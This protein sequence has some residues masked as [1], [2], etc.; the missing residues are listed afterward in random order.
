MIVFWIWVLSQVTLYSREQQ[1][2][3]KRFHVP[4]RTIGI[5]SNQ[6]FRGGG[7]RFCGFWMEDQVWWEDDV[8]S[9]EAAECTGRSSDSSSTLENVLGEV[10]VQC[11]AVPEIEASKVHHD[12]ALM[13]RQENEGRS[14]NGERCAR[15]Y[16][17]WEKLLG[18]ARVRLCTSREAH[19]IS[20]L[21]GHIA[22]A[23]ECISA[24]FSNRASVNNSSGDSGDSWCC[25]TRSAAHAKISQG[26]ASMRARSA[27]NV[28]YTGAVTP[29]GRFVTVRNKEF[30]KE[31]TPVMWKIDFSGSVFGERTGFC[32]FTSGF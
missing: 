21:S 30:C 3:W 11:D 28:A 4:T 5:T 17:W 19:C 6:E 23:T 8:A 25:E 27:N 16:C 24:S 14:E 13:L 15:N 18:E 20:K 9:L 32:V 10:H 26:K 22:V 7:W 31:S 1:C 12:L 2:T 29:R